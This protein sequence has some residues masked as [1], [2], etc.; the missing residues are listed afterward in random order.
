MKRLD[1]L[2]LE[3]KRSKGNGLDKSC[4]HK[5]EAKDDASGFSCII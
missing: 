4:A 5:M 2:Q 1:D 3:K